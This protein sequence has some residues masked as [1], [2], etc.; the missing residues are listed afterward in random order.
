MAERSTGST[1]ASPTRLPA[2][3][4]HPEVGTISFGQP[5]DDDVLDAAAEA[6]ADCDVFLAVGTSL[7]VRPAAGLCE[8]AAASGARSSSSTPSRRRTTAWPTRRPRA[9]RHAL[10]AAAPR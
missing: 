4:R 8:I 2:V 5:L 7:T 3:R 9:D 10:P 1:P 6:A